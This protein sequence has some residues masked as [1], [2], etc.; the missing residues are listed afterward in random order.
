MSIYN[1]SK[2]AQQQQQADP[3]LID[4]QRRRNENEIKLRNLRSQPPNTNPQL[5]Q[6]LLNEARQLWQQMA[7]YRKNINE[8][9]RSSIQEQIRAILEGDDAVL[10]QMNADDYVAARNAFLKSV[11][12]IQMGETIEMYS[13]RVKGYI[14][15][16][17]PSGDLVEPYTKMVINDINIKA[18]AKREKAQKE[19]N[20]RNEVAAARA[21]KQDQQVSRRK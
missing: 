5:E 13:E 2:T 11:P 16:Y 6:Q 12:P 9:T 15:Q 8:R 19:Q 1:T 3:T 4:I 14:Y 18:N 20:R 21:A 7:D 17:N 10:S